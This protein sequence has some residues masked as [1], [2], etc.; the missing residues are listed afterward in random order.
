MTKKIK[1][2]RTIILI[3]GILGSFILVFLSKSLT[4]VNFNGYFIYNEQTEVIEGKTV[5][6]V[7]TRDQIDLMNDTYIYLLNHS[8]FV[9]K[10]GEAVIFN[11]ITMDREPSL[12]DNLE[13]NIIYEYKTKFWSK[14]T[15]DETLG[16]PLY[17]VTSLCAAGAVVFAY[18]GV[19]YIVK[20]KLL[21]SEEFIS[22]YK[23]YNDRCKLKPAGFDD[24]IRYN[25]LEE[26]KRVYKE[27]ISIKLSKLKSKLIEIPNEKLNTR[28][29]IILKDKIILL[30][31][32]LT[33]DFINDNIMYI[34]VDYQKI[35]AANFRSGLYGN[36]I[37]NRKDYSD[38]NK[39]LVSIVI[40]K[41]INSMLSILLF[42]GLI[43]SVY[44]QMSFT[45]SFWLIITFTLFTVGLNIFFATIN[46]QNMFK[47]EIIIPLDNKSVILEDSVR[48]CNGSEDKSFREI[49]N[50]YL[51]EKIN[52]KKNKELEKT[53]L[54]E[55]TLNK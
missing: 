54:K 48:W 49:M 40:R 39:K 20:D 38:E 29:A 21:E 5:K 26:K 8:Y 11:I 12:T 24:Y 10:D 53:G 31:S 50:E 42:A 22:K 52:D 4:T 30:E 32:H 28:K 33:D 14:E 7:T 45:V 35:T 47:N 36:N 37:N 1:I 2:F 34:K 25:N 27:N 19:Y 43:W 23:T 17:W 44:F 46:S 15:F 51:Q 9:I 6:E 41:A 16:D 18:L 13:A 55:D 3:L